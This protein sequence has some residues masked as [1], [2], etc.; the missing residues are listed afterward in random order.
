M[1]KMNISLGGKELVLNY[2]AIYFYEYFLEYTGVDIF[3]ESQKPMDENNQM[4]S[5]LENS[6]GYFK[7]V[8]GLVAAGYRAECSVLEIPEEFDFNKIRHLIY[9]KN[10]SEVSAILDAYNSVM[11]RGN[12]KN[13][14]EKK[15]KSQANQ[16]VTPN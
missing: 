11:M 14:E 15:K 5:M 10:F 7:F 6:Q 12:Q 1:K 4:L 9:S 8:T 3:K 16:L 13:G 2:E